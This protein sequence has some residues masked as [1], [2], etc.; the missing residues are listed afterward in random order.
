MRLVDFHVEGFRSLK[1][2]KMEG[3]GPHVVLYGPNG[4]GKT[5]VLEALRRFWALIGMVTD[6]WRTWSPDLASLFTKEDFHFSAHQMHFEGRIVETSADFPEMH[7]KATVAR[8]AER[9]ILLDLVWK[10]TNA[11]GLQQLLVDLRREDVGKFPSIIEPSSF[12]SVARQWD[13]WSPFLSIPALRG[14]TSTPSALNNVDT[15]KRVTQLALHGHIEEAIFVTQNSPDLDLSARADAL[16]KL[17]SSPPLNRPPFRTVRD[18]DSGHYGIQEVVTINGKK[19]GINIDLAGLGVQQIYAILAGILLSG[20]RLVTLEEPEAHLYQPNS[21]LHLRR[22]LRQ[23]VPDPVSQLFTATHSSMFALDP[24]GYWEV[25]HSHEKGTSVERKTDLV[26][27]DQKHVVEPGAARHALL[28]SLRREAPKDVVAW[29]ANGKGVSA[30]EMIQ[31]LVDYDPLAI[32][33][34][35]DVTSAAIRVVGLQAQPKK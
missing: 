2:L 9:L 21:G 8:S 22:L 30:G 26:E 29:R 11:T 12:E 18:P 16:R 1:S 34:L 19:V 27:L 25:S 5:N 6:V 24:E 7:F 3:L 33:Y 4:A 10:A 31:L 20:A 32:D 35:Q 23:L 17:L 28:M 14:G 15:A 13:S